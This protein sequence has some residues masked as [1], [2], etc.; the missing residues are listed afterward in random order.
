MSN[1]GKK[2]RSNGWKYRII[3]QKN[4]YGKMITVAYYYDPT[5]KF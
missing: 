1:I 3:D 5:G 2:L 4:D